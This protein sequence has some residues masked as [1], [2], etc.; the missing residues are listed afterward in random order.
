MT[1]PAVE[2][3]QTHANI[4]AALSQ[5][6]KNITGRTVREEGQTYWMC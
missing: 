1:K 2:E 6:S 5:D 4:I 3:S